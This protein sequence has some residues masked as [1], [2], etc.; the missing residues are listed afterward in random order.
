M[1]EWNTTLIQKDPLKGTASNNYWPTTC[2]PMLRKILTVQI[3][4]LI[5]YLSISRRLFPKDSFANGPEAQEIYYTFANTSSTR[6]KRDGKIYLW[7]GLTTKRLTNGN[8]KLYITL[9]LILELTAGEK[10]LAEI[11]ILRGKVQGDA[12]SPLLFII[13]MIPLSHIL[14]DTNLINGK[15]RSTT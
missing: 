3:R 11:K 13:V 12:L 5:Y 9:I 10:S 6:A 1:T 8:T 7:R 15:K 4:E 14:R 2:L